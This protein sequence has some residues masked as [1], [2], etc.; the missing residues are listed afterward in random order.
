MY[1]VL[2]FDEKEKYEMK[3]KLLPVFFSE[4]NEREKQEYAEQLGILKN[5]YDDVAEFLEPQPV[6]AEYPEGIDAVLFPQMFGAVFEHKDD[7]RRISKPVIL[8][9]SPFSTVEMWDWE[10]VAWIREEIGLNVLTPYQVEIGKMMMRALA[11]KRALKEGVKFL[12]FQDDPGEGMQANIFKRMYWWAPECSRQIQ[13]AFGVKL[14]FKSYKEVNERARKIDD[15]QADQLWEERKLPCDGVTG[16]NLRKAVKLYIALKEMADEEGNVVGIGTNC[17]NESFFSE[18]T[19]CLAY[20]WL[21][22]YDNIT[23][24][25]EADLVS[26]I[27]KYILSTALELP[28]MMSN[29]YP[30]L[31]GMAALKHEKINEFPDIDDPDNHALAVHCGYLGF[32]PKCFCTEWTI[33]PKVLEIVNDDAIAIDCRMAEG[34]ITMVKLYPNMK[35]MTIIEAEIEKY[36]QYPGSDCRNGALIRYKNDCGHQAMEYLSSHHAVFI[37][38]NVTYLLRQL[39]K[40]YGFETIIM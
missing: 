20:E 32:A 38:G 15:R 30:F 3:A 23:W 19:P 34:P 6:E 17:L 39:A 28:M 1:G 12:L 22:T 29:I 16:E 13:D 33:R 5:V 21:H 40:I 35:K 27:S 36:V 31:V 8:I 2:Q 25:C 4:S 9:T 14:V 18:T 11:A 24:S 7:L 37:Q 26:L 10:I